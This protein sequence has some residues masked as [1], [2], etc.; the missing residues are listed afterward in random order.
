MN[1]SD[2]T[3]MNVQRSMSRSLFSHKT[4][5]FAA[6]L[7]QG[8]ANAASAGRAG[9]AVALCLSFLAT[10]VSHATESALP[11]SPDAQPVRQSRDDAWW[12][13]PLLA[14][15]AGTLPQGH[16]LFEPYL[17]DVSVDDRFDDDG[18]RRSVPSSDYYGSQSY[19]LY[20]LADKVTVGLIPRFGFSNPGT[21]RSSSGIG[22]GDLTFQGQYRLSQFE[23]GSWIPTTSFV[24]SETFPIGK[25]DRLGNRPADGLGAGAYTTTAALYSQY[26]LWM[27]NGRILRTR[28]NFAW[29]FSNDA[30]VDNVSVYGTG[31]GFHGHA[32]PGDS[33][34]LDAAWEYSLTRNWVLALDLVYQHD[35]S[36]RVRGRNF[37]AGTVEPVAFES[38]SSWQFQVAPAIEYN[39]NAN[40]GVIVGARWIAA[41]RNTSASITPVA[42]INI[43]Y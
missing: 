17:F 20:G 37:D 31:E 33:F 24:F 16:F 10:A 43:V 14:A 7:A 40:V 38:G 34:N 23:E 3:P 19:V 12:T 25:Y 5:S 21:G 15:G 42:A 4:V 1:A 30:R 13:G 36:T 39:W 8:C 26:Y 28:L 6:A 2:G 18:R 32:S 41:G 22:V 27:P 29:S 9:A 35:S 11:P